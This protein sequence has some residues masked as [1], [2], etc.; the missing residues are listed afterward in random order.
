MIVVRDG[1]TSKLSDKDSVVAIGVFDGLHRGHQSVID[2]LLTLRGRHGDE[3]VSTVVTFDPHPAYVLAPERAPRLIGTLDQRLEGLRTLG[4]EQV[5]V[6]TFD[7]ELASESASGFIQRVILNELRAREVVVGEDFRFGHDRAGDVALLRA[8]GERLGF[9][10][11]EAPTFGAPRWSSSAVRTALV[12]GDLDVAHD[13]LGRA[14]VLRG[15]VEHGDARGGDLGFATANVATEPRQL[16]PLDGIYAGAART[17]D[18]KWWPAAISIGTRPQFYEHGPVLVEVHL[19]GFDGNLYD[20]V[21]DVAFVRRL[22]DEQV[23]SDVDALVAQIARDVAQ[24]MEIFKKF[25]SNASA[26]L[27]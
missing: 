25:S 10:V 27:E 4:V 13:V 3:A 2:L 7:L 17:P 22:R 21:L 14:F 26:L 15:R 11:H 24:T 20:A 6:L 9:A 5:R 18:K 1:E 19:P 12:A 23:F 16:V 8:E